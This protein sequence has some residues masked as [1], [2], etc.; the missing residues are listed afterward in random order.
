MGDK[1]YKS[2]LKHFSTAG[3]AIAMDLSRSTTSKEVQHGNTSVRICADC[4]HDATGNC[5]TCR[6]KKGCPR[7]TSSTPRE[8]LI[9]FPTRQ[10]RWPAYAIAIVC[11]MAVSAFR[12]GCWLGEVAVS[13][14][15][16]GEVR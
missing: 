9:R 10:E 6:G 16:Y 7:A 12:L 3:S 14:V 15:L 5:I 13:L 1:Y 8:F 11:L 2:S 4:A